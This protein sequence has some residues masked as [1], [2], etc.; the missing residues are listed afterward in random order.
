MPLD[1]IKKQHTKKGCF[2]VFSSFHLPVIFL[3][4]HVMQRN[5]VLEVPECSDQEPGLLVEECER[6][7]CDH[8][9]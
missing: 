2:S 8:C 6:I 3:L 4:Q 7:E 5:L 1:M 9:S